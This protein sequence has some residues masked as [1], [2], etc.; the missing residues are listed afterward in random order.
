M[1]AMKAIEDWALQAYVDGELDAAEREA[2]E[3]LLAADP[4]ARATV[5]AYSRQNAALRQAFGGVLEEA[6]PSRLSAAIANRVAWKDQPWL[7][8]AAAILLLVMGGSIGWLAGHDPGGLRAE[9]IADNAIAAHEIYTA[10]VKHPVEV[11]AADRDQMQ[12]WLSKRIGVAFTVPDLSEQ[13]YTLLGGRLLAAQDQPAAQ[14]MYEDAEKKRI[15]IFLTG[16]PDNQKMAL[17]VEE[18]GPLIACYWLD[19][20]LGFVV[21]GEMDRARMMQLARV[22]YDR[23]ES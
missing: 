18:K 19:G 14:L 23:F 2:V 13:G 16:N 12:A 21:A 5:E 20:P 15:T 6:V 4:Q 17:R 3:K 10:E 22:I 11:L 9:T 1:T 8:M 7:R